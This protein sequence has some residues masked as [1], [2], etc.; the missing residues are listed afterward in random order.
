VI[1]VNVTKTIS[2]SGGIILEDYL[3]LHDSLMRFS[4]TLFPVELVIVSR[5]P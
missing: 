1:V 4:W 5:T 3:T 2:R